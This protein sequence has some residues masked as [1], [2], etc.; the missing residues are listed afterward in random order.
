MNPP[1]IV[2][3]LV[4]D[5]GWN[6]VGYHA[7]PV[8]N[9]EIKTP[10]I[11]AYAAAG[12]KLER[13]YMTPWCGPSRAALMT[14]RTNS[15]NANVSTSLASFDDDIGY[16]AG[17]P[18]GTRTLATAFKEYGESIGKPYKAYYN[19]KWGIGVSSLLYINDDSIVCTFAHLCCCLR[20]PLGQTR[21]WGWDSMSFEGSGATES[22]PVVR[23]L[24]R[25]SENS[26]LDRN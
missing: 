16:V 14:G 15:Y 17:L 25:R 23:A 20:E 9:N 19:G 13:S 2:I 11:D 21:H 10:N 1:N 24:N 5:L 12:L 6:Q 3:F 7:N 26:A 22:S 4:D 18:S 8:G